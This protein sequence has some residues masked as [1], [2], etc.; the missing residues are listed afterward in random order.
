MCGATPTSHNASAARFVADA[1][2]GDSR[3]DAVVAAFLRLVVADFFFVLFFFAL[4]TLSVP[5]GSTRRPCP[6]V[7]GKPQACRFAFS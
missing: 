3:R 2:F 4:A 5:P 1:A 6:I 7:G